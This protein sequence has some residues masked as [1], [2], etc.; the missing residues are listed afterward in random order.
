[1]VHRDFLV[2]FLNKNASHGES[3][4]AGGRWCKKV[5]PS[6]YKISHK[7]V[8]YSVVTL[9]NNSN[10]IFE[11]RWESSLLKVLISRKTVYNCM[12]MLRRFF[13]VMVTISQY[14]Q[15]SSCCTP[16]TNMSVMLQLKKI[17]F[18]SRCIDFVTFSGCHPQ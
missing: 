7:D 10:N 14:M 8:R 13:V 12:A 3:W 11:S 6:G 16:A 17:P 9:I 18:M 2:F 15:I 4:A 1:M 5:Q